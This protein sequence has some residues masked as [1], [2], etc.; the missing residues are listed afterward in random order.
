MEKKS[1]D[2]S[3]SGENNNDDLSMMTPSGTDKQQEQMYV[4]NVGVSDEGWY[5]CEA[6]NLLGRISARLYL[7][8]RR[9]T[10]I[11]DAPQNTSVTKGQSATLTCLVDKEEDVNVDL[12]WFFND[13]L[14]DLPTWSPTSS[15]SSFSMSAF[16]YQV[17]TS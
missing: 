5:E 3:T 15:V 11:L 9:R 6:S 12:R 13:V 1:S 4:E 14:I 7:T 8:V 17:C 2:S 16:N 10:R